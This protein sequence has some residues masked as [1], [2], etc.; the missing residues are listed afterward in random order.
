MGGSNPPVD[1]SPQ[2]DRERDLVEMD[3]KASYRYAFRAQGGIL[4][5]L[6][7]SDN[8]QPIYR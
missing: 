2:L 1:R 5:E 8:R 6:Q 7:I 4:G 3:T